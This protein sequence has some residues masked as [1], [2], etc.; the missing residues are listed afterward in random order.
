[1]PDPA[2]GRL[3]GFELVDGSLASETQACFAAV[4]HEVAWTG[5]PSVAASVTIELQLRM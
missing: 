5:L 2:R 1:M 4:L 3:L